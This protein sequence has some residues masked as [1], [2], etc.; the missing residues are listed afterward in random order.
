[1]EFDARFMRWIEIPIR[2]LN[3]SMKFINRFALGF[4]PRGSE[5]VSGYYGVFSPNIFLTL[6]EKIR[7]QSMSQFYFIVLEVVYKYIAWEVC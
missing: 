6:M 5:P 3:S 7:L 1:M 2:V 4:L